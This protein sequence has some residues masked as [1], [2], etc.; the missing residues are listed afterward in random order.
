[1]DQRANQPGGYR[2]L[3]WGVHLAGIAAWLD[4]YAVCFA[5]AE[6]LKATVACKFCVHR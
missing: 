1:M 2:A 5:F 3:L 6:R 4:Q